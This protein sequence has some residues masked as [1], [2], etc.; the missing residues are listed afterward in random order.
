MNPPRVPDLPADWP[1]T[2]EQLAGLVTRTHWHLADVAF[3]LPRGAVS[4]EGLDAA[5]E[6]LEKLAGLL[7][8]HP[9]DDLAGKE[10]IEVNHQPPR[11]PKCGGTISDCIC[12]PDK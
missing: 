7:R 9:V 2:A 12:P 11:C 6:A 3:D 8:N 4:R 5:A 10:V 1:P